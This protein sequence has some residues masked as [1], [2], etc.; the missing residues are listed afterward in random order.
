[1]CACDRGVAASEHIIHT[2][3]VQTVGPITFAS[4]MQPLYL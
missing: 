3:E 4:K 1:M 2:T